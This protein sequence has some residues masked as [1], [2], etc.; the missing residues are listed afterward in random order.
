MCAERGGHRG[1]PDG[2]GPCLPGALPGRR[3]TQQVSTQV[4][5]VTASVKDR[6]GHVKTW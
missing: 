5:T 6:D 3:G 1:E 2:R 4:D